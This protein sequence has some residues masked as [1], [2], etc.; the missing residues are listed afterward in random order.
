MRWRSV[1]L[2]AP[3]GPSRPVTPGAERERDVVD[4]DDVAVP[5]RDVVDLEAAA[6][7]GAAASASDRDGRRLRVGAVGSVTPRSAGSG[8]WSA[9]RRW[10]SRRAAVPTYSQPGRSSD[11]TTGLSG[12][13]PKIAAF[14]PSSTSV[15]LNRTIARARSWFVRPPMMATMIGGMMKTAMID[16]VAYARR[17]VQAAITLA[18]PP[19]SPATRAAWSTKRGTWPISLESPVTGSAAT[20]TRPTNRT[21]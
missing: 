4:G 7:G 10:R 16:A 11:V 1:D 14:V 8:G 17:G 3:F 9:R 21:I 18:S 6:G 19:S 2:P 15:G 20:S 5:A 12:I 13:E